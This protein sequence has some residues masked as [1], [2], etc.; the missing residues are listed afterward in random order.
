[1]VK[2]VWKIKTKKIYYIIKSDFKKNNFFLVTWKATGAR[3][4]ADPSTILFVYNIS[5][6]LSPENL[7]NTQ[8]QSTSIQQQLQPTQYSQ[9]KSQTDDE[10]ASR[11]IN[12]R[13]PLVGDY[14]LRVWLDGKWCQLL[15][16]WRWTT[17]NVLWEGVCVYICGCVYNTG[18]HDI[19]RCDTYFLWT[20][21]V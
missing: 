9:K 7:N 21:T 10:N 13:I 12:E 3:I 11:S 6:S 4:M 5:L 20:L 18:R 19:T 17:V 16:S 8:A 2:P 15:T 14:C 1:M